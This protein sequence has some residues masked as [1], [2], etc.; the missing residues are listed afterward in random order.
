MLFTVYVN[1]HRKNQF[2][3][4]YCG[5]RLR[6]AT[7]NAVAAKNRFQCIILIFTCQLEHVDQYMT[8]Q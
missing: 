4:T 2:S 8:D 3:P 1:F 7:G 5:G 6:V